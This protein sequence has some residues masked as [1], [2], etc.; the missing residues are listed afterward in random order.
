M[1]RYI[2]ILSLGIG[3]SISCVP[4]EAVDLSNIDY[5]LDNPEVIQILEWQDRREKDSLALML[6]E[7]KAFKRM[8]AARALGVCK[9]SNYVQSLWPLLN[10][11]VESV[12][13]EAIFSL[14]LIGHS[15]SESNLIK[16]FRAVDSTGDF[17]K[18]NAMILEALG[19]CGQDSTLKM[20]CGIKTYSSD[21]IEYVQGQVLAWFRYGLRGKFCPES[22]LRIVDI[23]TN[24]DYDPLSRLWAAHSLMRFKEHDTKAYFNEL[25][26]AAYEEKDADTRLCIIQ[27][28]ARIGSPAVLSELEE[29]YRRGLDLRVQIA[30]VKGLQ[31][32]PNGKAF[33][34]ASKAL[35]NPSTHVGIQAAQY[36]IDHGLEI[37]EDYLGNIMNQG[38]LSWQVKTMIYEALLKIVPDY[39][40]LTISG[41]I[42]QIKTNS[43]KTKNSYERAAYIRAMSNEYK[44]IGWLIR[45]F[46]SDPS[47]PVQ[48]ALTETVMKMVKKAIFPTIY[49]GPKNKIYD[50]IA[51]YLKSSC[52]KKRL[53]SISVI[54]DAFANNELFYLKAFFKADSI[55]P[56]TQSSLTL[57]K[58]I[59]TYNDLS[60][61]ISRLKKVPA[62]IKKPTY[63]HPIEWKS[64]LQYKD[65]IFIEILT[66]KGSLEC[67]LYSKIAPGS[68]SNMLDLISKNYY[69]G[70]VIHRV[71]PNFVIQTGCPIGDGYGSLDY[72]IRTEIN[73]NI[74]YN[75][76]GRI[77]MASAGNDTESSQFFITYSATPHLDGNYTI[78]GQLTKGLDILSSIN[79]G[80]Q[81]K[82]IRILDHSKINIEQQ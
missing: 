75:I 10:D 76:P 4:P 61:A 14:G 5:Q 50:E 46:Q 51:K 38:G 25:K 43:V 30:I 3:T 21:N 19:R 41:L 23:A 22:T 73:P 32:Y 39:K 59:E 26:K 16:A 54:S 2:L 57:P 29:L 20:I 15:S 33:A 37:H 44:E 11:P 47:A 62:D 45:Q 63:N 68:V 34:L 7:P 27:A 40:V 49:Q 36:F 1:L 60:K 8:L 79:V 80:D 66:D 56:L 65:T 6:S 12:K 28:F 82:S 67:E 71:V 81:V 52:E 58:D 17:N 74:H 18:T 53:G 55:L 70:K 24:K 31:F 78:F 9:D 13:Q 77:G 42:Q 72:T 69:D 35:V 48:T 64:I